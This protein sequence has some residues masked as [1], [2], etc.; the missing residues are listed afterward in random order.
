MVL[1]F[2]SAQTPVTLQLVSLCL[3]PAAWPWLDLGSW[4]SQRFVVAGTVE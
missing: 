2:A 1:D 4:V 3:N